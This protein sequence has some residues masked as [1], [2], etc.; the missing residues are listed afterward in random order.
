LADL[1]GLRSAKASDGG[2]WPRVGPQ[3]E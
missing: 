1:V 2:G 3:G